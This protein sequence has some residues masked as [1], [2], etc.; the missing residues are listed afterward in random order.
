MATIKRRRRHAREGFTAEM[1]DLL[2]FGFAA[3]SPRLAQPSETQVRDAW[4][5]HRAALLCECDQP[6]IRPWGYW[7]FDIGLPDPLRRWF[8]Q[9][10]ELLTRGLI[11]GEEAVRAESI[12]PI[13]AARQ[14]TE[15]VNTFDDE[16]SIRRQPLGASTAH[17]L[18]EAFSVAARWHRWRSRPQL[19]GVY[20]RRAALMYRILLEPPAYAGIE[21]QTAPKKETNA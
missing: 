14:S 19:A 6:C 3:P 10:A 18:A 15:E 5:L 11:G 9:A 20:E 7:R 17:G 1:H 21:R 4:R 2:L 16:A 12:Y 8:S 13:L